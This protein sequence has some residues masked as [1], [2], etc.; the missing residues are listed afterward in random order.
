MLLSLNVELSN[1]KFTLML[2]I[3]LTMR[4][5]SI[6]SNFGNLTDSETESN[7][8]KVTSK[9]PPKAGQASCLQGLD[10][11]AVTHPS[12][13][14]AQRIECASSGEM[15]THYICAPQSLLMELCDWEHF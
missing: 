4:L 6:S 13:S 8:L 14:L 1:S 10:H 7:G 5:L 15:K 2:V 12:S 3:C 11:S 9:P